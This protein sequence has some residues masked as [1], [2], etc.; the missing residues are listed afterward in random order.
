MVY[1]KA[2][3]DS[4]SKKTLVFFGWGPLLPSVDTEHH[5]EMYR[6]DPKLGGI[7][8]THS[9]YACAWAIQES[10][11]PCLSTTMADVFGGS[12]P[13][14]PYVGHGKGKLGQCLLRHRSCGP[15]VLA[16]RHGVFAFDRSV[17]LALKAAAVAEESA[18]VAWL[19]KK[20]GPLHPFPQKEA[21]K[22]WLRYQNA[23]GQKTKTK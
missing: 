6:L 21:K 19:A 2:A 1:Q 13:C 18:R 15:V 9:T 14:A 5:L 20:L 23:Y 7:V 4:K 11:I 10:P 22:W 12:I 8:H 3:K 17:K 16:A